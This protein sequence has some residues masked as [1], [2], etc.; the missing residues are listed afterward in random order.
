MRD[1]S[2]AFAQ[3]VNDAIGGSLKPLN[4]TFLMFVSAVKLGELGFKVSGRREQRHFEEGCAELCE[5]RELA[6]FSLEYAVALAGR[7]L[8][9]SVCFFR[10]HPHSFAVLACEATD[11]HQDCFDRLREDYEIWLEMKLGGPQDAKFLE[12]YRRSVFLT[13]PVRYEVAACFRSAWARNNEVKALAVR[14]ASTF[15]G[16]TLVEDAFQR[17]RRVETHAQGNKEMSDK[18]IAATV[19]R[20]QLALA[21]HLR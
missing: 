7:R 13:A 8:R 12:I 9:A 17:E 3:N 6:Q 16:T 2:E 21:R 4:E 5:E 15:G 14:V 1:L 20:K 18:T 11:A 10:G 19:L